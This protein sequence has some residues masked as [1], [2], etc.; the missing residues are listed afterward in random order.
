MQEGKN[1]EK[2]ELKGKTNQQEPQKARGLRASSTHKEWKQKWRRPQSSFNE[3]R[4]LWQKRRQQQTKQ[5]QTA[6]QANPT[7]AR[8]HANSAGVIKSQLH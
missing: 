6:R 4:W 3:A 5:Q 7:I 1:T 2:E 8:K